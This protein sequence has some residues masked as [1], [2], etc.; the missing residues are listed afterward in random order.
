MRSGND[1]WIAGTETRCLLHPAMA[2]RHGLIAGAT[3]TGKS[4]TLKVI[5]ESF[6]DLGVPIFLADIKGDMSGLCLP[7][8]EN[9][10]LRERVAKFGISDFEYKAYPTEFFDVFGVNGHPLR[11]TVSEMGPLLLGRMLDLSDVQRAVLSMVFRIADEQGLLLLDLKDLRL[12]LQYVGDHADDF[13]LSHGN[14]SKASVGAIQRSIALL[15]DQGAAHFFGEPSFDISDWMKTDANGKGMVNILHAVELYSRPLLYSTFVLWLLSELFEVLPEVGDMEKPK[16]IFFFDEAHLLFNDAPKYL[17]EKVEQVIR[18]I[19]SKGVGVYFVTQNP[20]DV[21]Q[22]VLSQLGNRVQ[23]ALRA[24]TPAEQK[25]IRAAAQ[26]F[27]V[28]DAFDTET[29]LTEL[30]TGEALVSFLSEKGVPSVVERALVLP[31]QSLIG[32]AGEEKIRSVVSSS[33]LYTKYL[34]SL[35]RTSAYEMLSDKYR[36]AEAVETEAARKEAEEKAQKEKQKEE[37]AK[38]KEAA[39]KKK[40]AASSPIGKVVSSAAST[41]GR[42]IGRRLIRGLLGGFLK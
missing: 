23:H 12:M 13:I 20:S 9:G 25:N 26:S 41:A 40:K 27:R 37:A 6:S 21:P 30:A 19:R 29:V 17:I 24:Y 18:L 3:G 4:V 32:P 8:I 1:L 33:L 22:I 31:P 36:A 10:K 42:E 15:E 28:N 38:A 39:A 11:V 7:G 34:E 35:D 2:N 14:V 5:A 16:M